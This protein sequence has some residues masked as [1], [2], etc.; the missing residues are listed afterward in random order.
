M[1]SL[2]NIESL[3]ELMA[4]DDG[5]GLAS[6][7]LA[8]IEPDP[9]QP[10]RHFDQAALE[11]LAASIKAQG[12]LQPI[13]VRPAEQPGR[14]LIVAGERRW[15]ACA[16]ADVPEIPAIVRTLDPN[17]IAAVQL[18]ENVDRAGLTPMEE[19][20]AV[21]AMCAAGASGAEVARL[22]GKSEGWVSQRRKVAGAADVLGDLADRCGDLDALA[23]LVDLHKLAPRHLERFRTDGDAWEI[24]RANVRRLLDWE[25]SEAKR[26]EE[27]ARHAP[28]LP[29]LPPR[30]AAEDDDED[31]PAP[32]PP[33]AP[34]GKPLRDALIPPPAADDADEDQDEAD[35]DTAA[36]I[37]EAVL[38]LPPAAPPGQRD[39][40]VMALEQRMADAVGC[41]VVVERDADG[42]PIA[43]SIYADSWRLIN[44]VAGI[45]AGS[46]H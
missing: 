13:I 45:L 17:A 25:R 5:A 44:R 7:P 37:I 42:N 32:A 26:R 38:G 29:G 18:V 35:D 30:P 43:V 1:T 16:L 11:T 21:A 27:E 33:L 24:T 15:R 8:D 28:E 10:R 36:G 46:T 31:A 14:Y 22:I 6:L 19:A 34:K 2:Q 41:P 12:V 3:V 40:A 20:R 39:I 4:A 23:G 9:T